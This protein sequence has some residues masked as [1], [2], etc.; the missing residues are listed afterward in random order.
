MD[1]PNK[2][3]KRFSWQ[4]VVLAL[5]LLLVPI[6]INSCSTSSYDTPTTSQTS[7]TLISPETLKAWSNSGVVNSTGFDRVV[8]LDVTSQATYSAGHIPG[9]QFMNSNDLYQNRQ[10]GPATDVNMVLDGL[11]MDAIVQKY[12]ID[13]NTTI[14]F[15]SGAASPVAGSVLN[16][17]RAYWMFRYWG[18]PKE[19]L[20]VLDGINFSWSATYGGLTTDPSPAITPS[21]YSVKNNASLRSDLRSSLGDMI[22]VAKGITANTVPVDMRSSE[23][24][25]SYIGKRG[26]TTG[27]FSPGSDYVTFEGRV[28]GGRA[29]LYTTM[30]DSANN[31]RFKAP[32]VLTAMF[33]AIGVDST[34]TA[35]VY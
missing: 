27:V 6:L 13:K 12:G 34:K 24:D 5:C 16:A 28:K 14:V 35:H 19:K 22:N 3:R 10:E 11:H 30:L 1:F 2:H 8:I 23:T 17:T 9:A 31:Y 15:T 18:F 29:L 7:A 25:G 21:S 4:L 26:S 33:T 32:D 20:K